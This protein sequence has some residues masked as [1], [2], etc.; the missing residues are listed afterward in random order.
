MPRRPPEPSFCRTRTDATFASS[1]LATIVLKPDWRRASAIDAR[2]ISVAY[3]WP[4]YRSNIACTS[5]GCECIDGV[6]RNP[7]LPLVGLPQ[8]HAAPFE[9]TDAVAHALLAPFTRQQLTVHQIAAVVTGRYSSRSDLTESAEVG[10]NSGG[11]RSSSPG[12]SSDTSGSPSPSTPS[13]GCLPA[14]R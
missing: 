14:S 10:P 3:P 5:W 1:T 2:A 13:A 6:S 4:V 12:R 8:P 9:Q 11:A 7:H